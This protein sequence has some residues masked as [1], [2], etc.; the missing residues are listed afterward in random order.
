MRRVLVP[1]LLLVPVLEIAT[2]IWVGSLIGAGWTFLL[3]LAGAALGGWLV[4]REGRRAW[5]ELTAAL[6]GTAAAGAPPAAPGI[7][8][9]RGRG[10]RSGRNGREG[11]DTALVMAGAL[12]LMMPGFLTDVAALVLLLPFTR[13]PM[14]RALG[15]YAARRVREAEE[16]LF[17]PLGSA[18]GGMPGGMP[19]G[20]PGAGFPFGGAARR[21]EQ[22]QRPSG[23]VVQGEV[24]HDDD[25]P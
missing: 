22:G 7:E 10:G 20:V 25:R 15:R 14:R 17:T 13:P 6:G 21:P 12:L 24:L 23:P 19:G 8:G 18:P 1:A 3:L 5:G 11:L 2:I 16:Q 9:R 4:Q